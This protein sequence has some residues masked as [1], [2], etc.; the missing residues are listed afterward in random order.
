MRAA[1]AQALAALGARSVGVILLVQMD[2]D[3]TVYLS[4]TVDLEYDGKLWLGAGRVGA[5]SA[6]QD[7][8][9]ERQALRFSLSGVPEEHLAISLD[10][11]LT[12]HRVQ[13]REALLDADTLEVLDAPV[14]WTGSINQMTVE[15][16]SGSSTVS[17]TAEHRGTTFARPRPLRYTDGDQQRV[18][19]GDRALQFVVSQSNGKVVWPSASFFRK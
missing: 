3:S 13:I 14:V 12:G 4:S 17:V 19:V 9:S 1:A 18:A 15:D 16:A 11:T 6:I 7:G 8:V 2:L 10:A 5:I